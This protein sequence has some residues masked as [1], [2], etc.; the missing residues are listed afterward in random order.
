MKVRK[1]ETVVPA[2]EVVE[3]KR[4]LTEVEYRLPA[5]ALH[6][7]GR[8]DLD[9]E[10]PR[11]SLELARFVGEHPAFDVEGEEET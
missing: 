5:D 8:P 10:Q 4:E 7:P 3:K 2:L 1:A 9:A 11:G 6:P